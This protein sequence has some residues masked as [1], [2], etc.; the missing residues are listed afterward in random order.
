MR[1]GT[2]PTLNIKVS[3]IDL[4]DLGAI[5]ITLKQG[6]V[7]IDKTD[8]DI[9]ID[10]DVIKCT[11]TQDDTLKFSAKPVAVQLRALTTDGVAIASAIETMTVEDIL[12]E[13]KIT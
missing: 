10:G 8:D 2:T 13:G 1:R 11:L 4:S 5:Y 12:K 6:S 7:S 9:V 3:G